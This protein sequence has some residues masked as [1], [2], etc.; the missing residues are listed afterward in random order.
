MCCT[1]RKA[2]NSKSYSSIQIRGG[3]CND[4]LQTYITAIIIFK[5]SR[6]NHA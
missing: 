6:E 2:E 5:N 3:G 4:E 1:S